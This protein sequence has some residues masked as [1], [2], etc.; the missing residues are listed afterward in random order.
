[1]FDLDQ[2]IATRRQQMAAGGIKTRYVSNDLESHLRDEVDQ[3]VSEGE[4]AKQAFEAATQRVGPAGML[5]V[6][7]EKVENARR[8]VYRE[9]RWLFHI[10]ILSLDLLIELGCP[11]HPAADLAQAEFRISE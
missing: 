5:T 2:A 9:A 3:Q 8:F 4:D 6:E 11:I 1:M 7:F 10:R